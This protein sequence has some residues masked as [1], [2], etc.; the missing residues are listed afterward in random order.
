MVDADANIVD[1]ISWTS[2]HSV[3]ALTDRLEELQSGTLSPEA[4]TLAE[5]F[6]DARPDSCLL[7]TS[8]AADE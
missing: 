5:R 4:K 3:G 1:E 6:P 8:D 7:Y 2:K